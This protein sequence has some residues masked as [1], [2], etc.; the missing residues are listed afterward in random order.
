MRIL[1][2]MGG[3]SPEKMVSLESGES[4]AQGLDKKG[5]QVIKTDPAI[6]EKTYTILEKMHSGPIGDIPQGETAPLDQEKIITFLQNMKKYAVDLVFPVLHG[7]WGENGGIQALFE[8][9]GIPFAGSG[10]AASGLAMDKHLSK[11]IVETE[12]ILTPDYVFVPQ[13]SIDKIPLICKDFGYP[14][15]IKPNASGSSVGLSIVKSK[16]ELKKAIE[17]V[18][19]ENDDVLIERYI[20]GRELTVGI[21]DGQGLSVVEIVPKSGL[22]DYKHKY[23]AGNTEYICPAPISAGLTQ[24]C[25][26]QASIAFQLLGCEVFGRVDFRLGED[27]KLY[28]LE[29][30]TLP[31]M[32]EHSLVPKAAAAAGLNFAELVNRIAITSMNLKR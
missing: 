16:P 4:V 21:L 20:P 19:A 10:S 22:Y 23:T 14:L 8:I 11:R 32:T 28:F 1:V 25:I 24:Q 7:G 5:H 26:H 31:G 15:V 6:P 12:G 2:L 29:V 13:S 3:S 27:G 18:T 30:N 17:L 9:A